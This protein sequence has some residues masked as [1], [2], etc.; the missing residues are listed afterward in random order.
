MLGASS[1]VSEP[2]FEAV[3]SLRHHLHAHPETGFLERDT[4]MLLRKLLVEECG[5][6]EEE[7]RGMA[8]TGLVV[9]LRGR[10]A[11]AP[12]RFPE[13][14]V[15]AA[16]APDAEGGV[17]IVA[18]RTDIDALPM[19][20]RN[21]HLSYRSTRPGAAHSTFAASPLLPPSTAPL[22]TPPTLF[23]RGV[24]CAGTTDTW[25]A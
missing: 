16:A 24:Q 20:E 4:S 23:R 3:R 10:G 22:A 13:G 1:S 11:E 6:A 5:I 12:A 7:I 8:E 9:D 15:G 19:Q 14:S 17:R 2:L 21:E 25:R 18:L